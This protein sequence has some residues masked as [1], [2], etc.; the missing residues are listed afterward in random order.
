MKKLLSLGCCILC[1]H[2]FSK[3]PLETKTS[4]VKVLIKAIVGIMNPEGG[5]KM[6]VKTAYFS[7]SEPF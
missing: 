4:D 6:P 5:K 3:V 7:S 1:A 2:S